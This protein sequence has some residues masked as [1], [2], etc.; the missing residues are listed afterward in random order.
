MLARGDTKATILTN[1]GVQ[2]DLRVVPPDAYGNLLQHFTGSK[3]HN[4]AMREAA[5]KRGLKVSEW[6]IED[7]ETG[8]VRRM[9]DEREVYAALGYAWIPP[10]LREQAG[11]LEAARKDELPELLEVGDLRGDLHT[12]TVASDGHQTVE[13]MADG[14]ARAGLR[15]PRDHGPRLGRRHGHGP[16]RRGHHRPVRRSTS[17]RSR[18]SSRRAAW[19]CSRASR[20]TSCPRATSTSRT[21]CSRS[22]TGSWRPCTAPAARP[23]R[24]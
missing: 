1:D 4:V 11:E 3:A 21:R 6:G 24:R 18:G 19:C 17:A 20:R 9:A 15:V 23:A 2:V 13:Q 10:E 12:H 16:R 8:E 7:E 14:R 22:S 5:Q